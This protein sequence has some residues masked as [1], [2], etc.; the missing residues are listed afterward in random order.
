MRHFD[1]WLLRDPYSIWHYYSTGRRWQETIRQ[2]ILDRQI[3]APPID[4]DLDLDSIVMTDGD[5]DRPAARPPVDPYARPIAPQ[6]QSPFLSKLPPEVRLIIY[7]YVFG[8]QA[9]HLVQLKGKI[10]HVRCQNQ[11]SSI[12]SNRSCCPVSTARWRAHDARDEAHAQSLLYPHTHAAL[13][14]SLSNS[15]LSLLRTCRAIYAEAADI[16]YDNIAFDVDDLHTFIAFSL[17]VHP[18]HLQRIKR[19]TVQWMPVWQP[20]SGDVRDSSI[21]SYTHNDQLWMLFWNRVAA[22]TGLR[23]LRICLDLGRFS[24]NLMGGV[25]GGQ[26][27]HLALD[28]PWVGPILQVRGLQSF[29]LGITVKCDR[30]AKRVMEDDLKR[31]TVTLRDQLR[32]IVCSSPSEP[33][34]GVPCLAK[35]PCSSDDQQGRRV[36]RRLA[37]TA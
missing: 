30:Y 25:I 5:K 24:G 33:L 23:E 27:L 26:R 4:L 3:C 28:E 22:L 21:F 36:K 1:A 31:D 34:P 9:V 17:S 29:D 7:N 32:R 18:D 2:M 15:S 20:M 19:L 8:D 35:K 10:R 37:I 11:S 16:P 13:P 6:T 14:E 12:L